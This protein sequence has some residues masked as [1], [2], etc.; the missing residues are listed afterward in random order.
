MALR[1]SATSPRW[2]LSLMPE[3]VGS[4]GIGGHKKS[5]GLRSG[6]WLFGRDG[7]IAAAR[8]ELTGLIE[9]EELGFYV[10]KDARHR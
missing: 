6:T 1:K 4:A 3:L 8:G 7:L 9:R 5:S 2:R 10:V